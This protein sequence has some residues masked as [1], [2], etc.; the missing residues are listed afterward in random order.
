MDVS[1]SGSNLD[2]IGFNEAS[3][4]PIPPLPSSSSLH[5]L[6]I[7]CSPIFLRPVHTGTQYRPRLK[8]NMNSQTKKL[9]SDLSNKSKCSTKACS[10]IV[11]ELLKS[12]SPII[13][14]LSGGFSDDDLF[15]VGKD[16][17]Y[18]PDKGKGNVWNV[19][20]PCETTA[21]VGTIAG[22]VSAVAMALVGAI[23]SYISYQKKKL[24]F[25]LQRMGDPNSV[26]GKHARD[27]HSLILY[28]VTRALSCSLSSNTSTLSFSTF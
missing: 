10:F 23:S 11:Y 2:E 17:T 21:E 22:I 1:I 5:R 3:H 28:V 8:D 18:K 12:S 6:A 14:S 24:C 20:L 19:T 27:Q 7:I 13:W 4:D 26:A 9:K 25:G 16:N 15:D